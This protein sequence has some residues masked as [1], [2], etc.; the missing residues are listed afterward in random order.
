MPNF[1]GCNYRSPNYMCEICNNAF[2]ETFEADFSKQLNTIRVYFS[3]LDSR[4]KLPPP[5]RRIECEDGKLYD[6]LPGGIPR[7]SSPSVNNVEHEDGTQINAVYRDWKEAKRHLVGLKDKI[8]GPI[9]IKKVHERIGALK[10]KLGF[11]GDDAHRVVAKSTLN[12]IARYKPDILDRPEMLAL[13]DYVCDGEGVAKK[14]IIFDILNDGIVSHNT[15]LLDNFIAINYCS[16]EP[17]LRSYFLIFGTF[18]VQCEIP[19][20]SPIGDD[21]FI[22]LHNDPIQRITEVINEDSCKRMR[23][24]SEC[25]DLWFEGKHLPVIKAKFERLLSFYFDAANKE[26]IHSIVD[27]AFDDVLGKPNGDEVTEEDA[28]RLT[29]KLTEKYVHWAMH[30]RKEYAVELNPSNDIPN[31]I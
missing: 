9:N 8:Q 17:C 7:L 6:L 16:E 3:I 12:M 14:W 15:A 31:K 11:G 26:Q 1:L 28:G 19:L 5:E 20:A 25:S 2:G 21:F 22:A 13:R 4:K 30:L 23:T 29:K 10:H 24:C 18:A 27:E